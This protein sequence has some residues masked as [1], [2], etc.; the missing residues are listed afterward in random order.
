MTVVFCHDHTRRLHIALP[1][2]PVSGN[3]AGFLF[4]R[5]VEAGDLR[6]QVRVDMTGVDGLAFSSGR[7]GL[8]DTQKHDCLFLDLMKPKRGQMP[9]ARL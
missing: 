4:S 3:F 1:W 5:T 9:A 7:L 2:L 6:S 8:E